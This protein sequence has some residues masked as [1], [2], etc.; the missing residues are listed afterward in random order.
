MYITYATKKNS[1]F[2]FDPFEDS[3]RLNFSLPYEEIWIQQDLRWSKGNLYQDG[4]IQRTRFLEN[5]FFLDSFWTQHLEQMDSIKETISWRSYGQQNPLVE[6]QEEAILSF[7]IL[8]EKL[9]NSLV[10]SFG[11]QF[12]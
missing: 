2:F 7:R 9:Q 1:G 8:F 3:S 5:L 11:N 12:I 6:Y 4:L 10:Y